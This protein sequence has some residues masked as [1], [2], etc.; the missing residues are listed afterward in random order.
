MDRLLIVFVAT[1][2]LAQPSAP[3]KPD[4]PAD[5]EVPNRVESS[6][7][8]LI[9]MPVGFSGDL[10]LARSGATGLWLESAYNSLISNNLA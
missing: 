8:R 4:F 6:S 2:A 9:Q 7:M 1:A 10:G 3:P 5:N